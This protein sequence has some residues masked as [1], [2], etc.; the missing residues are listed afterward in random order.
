MR[1]ATHQ[2]TRTHLMSD[3]ACRTTSYRLTC[4]GLSWITRWSLGCTAVGGTL[5]PTRPPASAEACFLR[6]GNPHEQPNSETDV[7][8]YGGNNVHATHSISWPTRKLGLSPGSFSQ[9]A[10][11]FTGTRRALFRARPNMSPMRRQA[12]AA[13]IEQPRLAQVMRPDN[14][15]DLA[16]TS[17]HV[18]QWVCRAGNSKASAKKQ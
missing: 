17:H 1:L 3:G 2:C 4:S 18:R 10:T 9:G 16:M 13:L 6:K 5:R 12:V 8:L 7:L 11:R 14:A 15:H